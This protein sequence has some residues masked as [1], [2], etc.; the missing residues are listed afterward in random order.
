MACGVC[1]WERE[2]RREAR[3]EEFRILFNL[4]HTDPGVAI[5]EPLLSK[6][7]KPRVLGGTGAAVAVLV[8]LVLQNASG[9]S[10]P[11]ALSPG[12]RLAVPIDAGDANASDVWG[13]AIAGAPTVGIIILNPSSGPGER[14]DAEYA[15][16]SAEAQAR[17][18]NVL[19]YV[20]TEWGNG[21]VPVNQ[22]EEWIDEYYS[23]YHVDGIMLDEA[24]DTCNAQPLKFYTALYDYV[25]AKTGPSMVLL[26][27]GEA[28]GECYAAIS[29]VLLTFENDYASYS[30]GY[31]GAS[32]TEG[33]P[34]SRFFHIVFGVP[35]VADMQY[36][37][38]NAEERGA[39]WVYVTN[40]DDS[41]GNP[42]SSLPYYFVQE[43]EYV[44]GLHQAPT[45]QAPEAILLILGLTA[46]G[47]AVVVVRGKRK[48][49]D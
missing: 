44:G 36:A 30:T 4:E 48:A 18:I 25:K 28:T 13:E 42:Y 40:L 41:K 20:Y 2:L 5:E 45:N 8:L 7:L 9:A 12:V 39:G 24:N 15:R 21:T 32:W 11:Q 22:A 1:E 17:G 26:N 19:G 43:L 31:A 35:T 3:R 6:S 14:V 33:F 29:D 37:I 27:P 23:W 16:L 46:T 47:S 34:P 10:P 38:S 49:A